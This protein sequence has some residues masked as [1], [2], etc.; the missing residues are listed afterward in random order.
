MT[1]NVCPGHLGEWLHSPPATLQGEALFENVLS[2]AVPGSLGVIWT[3][4]FPSCPYLART[5]TLAIPIIAA[6]LFFFVMSCLLQTSFTDPG[7]LPRA[8]ICEA[9]ALEKQIGEA[10][11]PSQACSSL[12]P[13]F[14]LQP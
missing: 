6:I 4:F 2:G 8:T 14:L 13:G 7:I 11:T 10:L 9:A 5:L 12:Q 3:L 1:S